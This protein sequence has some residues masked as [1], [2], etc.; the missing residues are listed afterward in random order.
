MRSFAPLILT[1]LTAACGDNL[2]AH[3]GAADASQRAA[4][5]GDAA[6]AADAAA[7]QALDASSDA[8]A[9]G[10]LAADAQLADAQMP[11]AAFTDAQASA[12]SS[13]CGARGQ[14]VNVAGSS[15]A[16]ALVIQ[17]VGVAY[18]LGFTQGTTLVLNGT[19]AGKALRI[20]VHPYTDNLT[21]FAIAPGTY[22]GGGIYTGATASGTML[23]AEG[24]CTALN[25]YDVEVVVDEHM[26]SAGAE[27]GDPT[28]LRGRLI[29]HDPA[30][31][32]NV[33][34]DIRQICERWTDV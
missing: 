5:A 27:V 1:V 11:E 8:R 29:V 9:D 12:C 24:L 2:T 28:V 16:G 22:R 15:P 30:W 21:S 23:N 17:T 33:P 26:P 25:P 34:F 3:Y 4:D 7:P 32:L 31:S 14:A 18:T 6:H 10:T 19:V 13:E 20:E